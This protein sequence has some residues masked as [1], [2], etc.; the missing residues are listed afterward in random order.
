MSQCFNPN[1]LHQNSAETELCQECGSKLLL[2][3]RYRAL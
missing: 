1:C 3:E 2:A